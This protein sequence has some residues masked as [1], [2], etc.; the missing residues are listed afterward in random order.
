M[1]YSF[2]D[3]TRDA[4]AAALPTDSAWRI[5]SASGS[6]RSNSIYTYLYSNAELMVIRVSDHRHQERET[7][8]YN[9]F[10]WRNS[11]NTERLTKLIRRRLASDH[12]HTI[13]FD[14][15]SFLL[16]FLFVTASGETNPVKTHYQW[17][18]QLMI[19]G[20][21][22]TLPVTI[23]DPDLLATTQ[24]L[25][26]ARLLHQ[27]HN[28]DCL[29]ITHN[30]LDILYQY[31]FVKKDYWPELS[32]QFKWDHVLRLLNRYQ[33]FHTKKSIYGPTITPKKFEVK[34]G[35]PTPKAW[36]Q[37]VIKG[38]QA[39]LSEGLVLLSAD[40]ITRKRWV[41][42]WLADEKKLYLV[43]FSISK[44]ATQPIFKPSLNDRIIS[45]DNQTAARTA[46]FAIKRRLLNNG[47]NQHLLAFIWLRIVQKAVK[48]NARITTSPNGVILTWSNDT[49]TIIP[50]VHLRWLVLLEN[51]G[52]IVNEAGH[53]TTTPVGDQV[54]ANFA[55]LAAIHNLV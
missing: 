3:R 13:P 54:I 35:P 49:C 10:Y 38:V 36:R 51:L 26:D 30:G 14:L 27:I 17:R 2:V 8:F 45:A 22:K 12:C 4:I 23:T 41:N 55:P 9:S 32:F 21:F 29:A 40:P 34:P 37:A 6:D 7:Y 1:V 53:Y 11:T 19:T 48:S 44:L 31:A 46:S 15:A 52:W 33:K 39:G 16:L 43:R 5:V 47:I 18:R 50:A 20:P 28:G 42:V 25:L 24:R